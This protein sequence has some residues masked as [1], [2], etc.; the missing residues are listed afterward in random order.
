MSPQF[1]STVVAAA[2]LLATMTGGES[3]H[4]PAEARAYVAVTAGQ[5]NAAPP[6][7][8]DDFVVK[9]DGQETAIISAVPANEPL[10][11]VIVVDGIASDRGIQVRSMLKSLVSTL[12]TKRPD[13]RIGFMLSEGS[14]APIITDV[15][16]EV[17]DRTIARFFESGRAAPLL[18][19]IQAATQVLEHEATSRRAI[20]AIAGSVDVGPTVA[21]Q[22][23]SPA[24]RRSKTTLWGVQIASSSSRGFTAGESVL[25]NVTRFS[26][27]RGDLIYDI[28]ALPGATQ[29]LVN[30]ML[31][32]YLLT[33]AVPP[34]KI[35]DGLRVGVRRQDVVVSAPA[36][37]RDP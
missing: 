19:S 20:L 1:P 25:A 27:G 16:S 29:N 22:R 18:E 11:L 30:A 10:A 9:L 5:G 13:S 36:W 31:S 17:T 32:Q 35:G 12:R 24:L 4:R 33:F 8:A 34:G 15:D 26:G 21:P 2:A 6:L 23:V 37:W 28:A 3:I 7:T 14:A